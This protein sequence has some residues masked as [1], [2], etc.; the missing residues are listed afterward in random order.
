MDQHPAFTTC[1]NAPTG[2]PIIIGEGKTR[3]AATNRWAKNNLNVRFLDGNGAWGLT[4]R[5]KVRATAPEWSRYANIEFHFDDSADPDIA[6]KIDPTPQF[7]PTSYWSWYGPDCRSYA[8]RGQPSMALIFPV[9]T[10]DGEMERVIRHEFGHALGLLHEH[11]RPD[12][13]IVWDEAAVLN[14]YSYTGWSADMI[15]EQIIRNFDGQIIDRTAFDPDSI[16]IYPIPPGLANITVG[17]MSD[18]SE[19]DKVLIARLYPFDEATSSPEKVL[20]LDAAPLAASIDRGRQVARFRFTTAV[21]AVYTVETQ[22]ATPLLL[23][24]SGH[25]DLEKTQTHLMGWDRGGVDGS[26]SRVT[27]TLAPGTYFAEARHQDQRNG[28]GGFTI[29]LRRS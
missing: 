14:Y 27:A 20:H 26:N 8:Q 19:M 28:T 1:A 15:R 5:D 9:N 18:L 3:A 13:G 17:M 6:I 24:L 11:K 22:G 23:T 12:S 4:V 29:T 21:P 2:G 25:R 16:M 10:A 7:V